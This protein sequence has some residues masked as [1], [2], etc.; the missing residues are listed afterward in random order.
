[1]DNQAFS[2]GRI[3]HYRLNADDA[4]QINRRRI[5]RR[6]TANDVAWPQG[7]VA[8]VGNMVHENDVFPMIITRVWDTDHINGQVFLDGNDLY[9]ATSRKFGDQPGTFCW[10]TRV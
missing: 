3:V 6:P 5:G 10:P 7:A 4:D 2:I 9:W 8:H 1:M